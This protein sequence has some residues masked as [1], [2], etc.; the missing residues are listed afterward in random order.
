MDIT[1]SLICFTLKHIILYVENTVI[2]SHEQ[3][4]FKEMFCR[5]HD[6]IKIKVLEQ[7]I[8]VHTCSHKNLVF[9]CSRTG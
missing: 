7:P 2:I 3:L 4:V 1:S 9:S 6:F 8:F 5:E